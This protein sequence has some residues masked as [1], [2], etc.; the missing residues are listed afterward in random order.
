MFKLKVVK[1]MSSELIR[2]VPFGEVLKDRVELSKRYELIEMVSGFWRL[3]KK[4]KKNYEPISYLMYLSGK[5]K[6]PEKLSKEKT[7]TVPKTTPKKQLSK[8]DIAL[9]ELFAL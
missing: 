8:R 7:K 6:E 5:R 1:Y 3:T 9:N 4:C 2:L